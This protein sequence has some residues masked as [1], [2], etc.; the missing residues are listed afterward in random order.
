MT[1]QTLWLAIVVGLIISTCLCVL[2]WKTWQKLQIIDAVK[3]QHEQEVAE[4]HQGAVTSI[5]V[6]AQC[7]LDEQVELSEGCI[8]LKILL[9]HVAPNLHEDSRFSIFNT[10]YESLKHMPTHEARKQTDKMTIF[11]LDQE[12]FKLEEDNQQ[13]IQSASKEILGY[14]F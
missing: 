1:Q 13:A 3:K 10:M 2:I 7:M 9:D 4:K 8:R 6:I 12:R 11:K 5:K 14:S